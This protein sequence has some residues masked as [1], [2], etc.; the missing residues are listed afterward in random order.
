MRRHVS[1]Q[2]PRHG[3]STTQSRK[4]GSP[5]TRNRTRWC[6]RHPA[7]HGSI[8]CSP[9]TE[10]TKGSLGGHLL[11]LQQERSLLAG[12][13]RT[14]LDGKRRSEDVVTPTSSE[15][16]DRDEEVIAALTTDSP[17][18][19]VPALL[20]AGIATIPATML[21]DSGAGRS[22][23]DAEWADRNGIS[24]KPSKNDTR[25]KAAGTAESIPIL[26]YTDD[27][28]VTIGGSS[29]Q[30]HFAIANTRIPAILGLPWL[31]SENPACDWRRG[32]V[33]FQD[34]VTVNI[35]GSLD[36]AYHMSE[37]AVLHDSSDTD[38]GLSAFE[39][40]FDPAAGDILPEHTV[41]DHQIPLVEGA[42][43]PVG[44]LYP[45]SAAED[46]LLTTYINE[47]LRKGF[48]RP[49]K[50]PAA[51]PCFFV[52]KGTD[53]RRLVVDYRALN[54]LT[55]KD[56]TPLPL[57]MGTLD[58]LRSAKMFT[59]L[60]L[61]GAYN[62]IRMAEGEEW[63]TA[64][65]TRYGLY[66]YTVMPF[67]LTN[68][69]ATFQ[70]MI[71]TVLRDYLDI[72]AVVY[73][74]DILVYSEDPA[75]H[76]G[77]VQ[78]VLEKLAEAK[79]AVK[80]EKC[81][82][83]VTEVD[84]LGYHITTRDIQMST[85]KLDAMQSYG[86]PVSKKG[87]QRFLGL[88]N[89]YRR[90]IPNYSK[91]CRPL[92]DL[93]ANVPYEWRDA[94]QEAFDT[95]KARFQE[96]P[97]LVHFDPEKDIHIETDA[98]DF[99]L[100]SVLSQKDEDGR[101]HPVAYYSR[102]FTPAERNYDIHD[103]ELL[104]VVASF[105]EWRPWLAGARQILVHTDHRNLEYFFARNVFKQRHWRW[106]EELDQFDYILRYRAGSMQRVA[107]A[108]SRKEE[109]KQAFDNDA[110]HDE[111]TPLLD[112]K[113]WTESH[114]PAPLLLPLET[115][116]EGPDE[117]DEDSS[118]EESSEAATESEIPKTIL[119]SLL[120]WNS[121]DDKFYPEGT[122][123]VNGL[124]TLNGRVRVPP[125]DRLRFKIVALRHDTRLAS[126]RGIEKTMEL[127]ARDFY[128]AGMLRTIQQYVSSCALCAQIKRPTHSPYGVLRPLPTPEGPWKSIS[129]DFIGPLPLSSGYSAILVVV[130]RFTKF[131]H[132]IPCANSINSAELASLFFKEIVRLHGFPES[133]VSDR[134]RLFGAP[135]WSTVCRIAG[136]SRDMSSS[137]H[138]Q[139]D[140]QTERVNQV[141]EQVLRL[142]VNYR[143][144]NWAEYL[145]H[146]E[147]SI[148]NSKHSS[149]KHTPYFANYGFHPRVDEFSSAVTGT[150][151][152]RATRYFD[153]IRG[154]QTMVKTAIENAKAK[155]KRFADRKRSEAPDYPDGTLVYVKTDNFKVGKDRTRKF[156]ATK[157][158]PYRVIEKVGSSYRIELPEEHASRHNVF[159]VEYLEPF[160]SSP[161][162]ARPE[163][164]VITGTR[165]LAEELQQVFAI[166]DLRLRHT[167]RRNT[168]TW[169]YLVQWSHDTD[170]T[171][172]RDASL[173]QNIAP[174][175]CRK[176]HLENR[177]E[178]WPEGLSNLGSILNRD[179]EDGD[180][181]RRFEETGRILSNVDADTDG[182]EQD[183]ETEAGDRRPG[184][185][186]VV[187]RA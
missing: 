172:W 135:F 161:S 106:R 81:R 108:L 53:D 128:W 35:A 47:N 183:V 3:G 186:E 163:T 146:V 121:R 49:S 91:I 78:K 132:C 122:P 117:A 61:R 77:H 43:P 100:G 159:H 32:T 169:Q 162:N 76:D 16:S 92:H 37:L 82:F 158:G 115:E 126:H 93:T 165:Y 50:S 24:W 129:M 166:L 127:V 137:Y 155:F 57:I 110:R 48:I 151:D 176:F 31:R 148:N 19:T 181:N 42:K 28:K 123:I 52:A 88:A 94:Q 22:V 18:W 46:R 14:S 168:R 41:Y 12:L 2:H 90:F 134:D 144:D 8:E 149:T 64:F 55:I 20:E 86:A 105:R 111:P 71:N 157:I 112:G 102:S 173:L 15:N 34:G 182:E 10:K 29:S 87:L 66:E 60:D 160:V 45:L 179:T 80:K 95:L 141:V 70:A 107:D 156:T 138:P 171:V 9:R 27:L 131:V 72:F 99:A 30:L 178:N 125:D 4:Y 185:A 54:A 68:A 184:T 154:V 167:P 130:D 133:I 63:K 75:E 56:R 118:D 79:L 97:I 69:P 139:T 7:D 58:R 36:W 145:P 114:E 136:A 119:D 180:P 116:E 140:G 83:S 59:Q 38:D 65:R 62:L 120:E 109:L 147:M 44:K 23:I 51:S 170:D 177:N 142:Y 150:P 153:E 73:L 5:K 17:K 164:L 124:A 98:S 67:G 26:G 89:F 175:E 85:D 33:T 84:F 39:Q 13:P 113:V 11:Q 1:V 187:E 103:K 40:I 21:I 143:Q 6:L 101:F 74:D 174:E 96:A 25:M 152:P 104:A